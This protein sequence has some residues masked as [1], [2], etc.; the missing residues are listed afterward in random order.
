[1]SETDV[2]GSG[3]DCISYSVWSWSDGQNIVL[4]IGDCTLW[5]DGSI[6]ADM[7][8]IPSRT[9]FARQDNLICGG[10]DRYACNTYKWIALA[11]AAIVLSPRK[12]SWP[13]FC[14]CTG[15]TNNWW[16][17]LLYDD[18]TGCT[19]WRT[20]FPIQH[21]G[22]DHDYESTMTLWWSPEK[23]R[24]Q[25]RVQNQCLFFRPKSVKGNSS[26]SH[27]SASMFQ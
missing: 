6:M 23:A 24:P 2:N 13:L 12:S 27:F 16:I 26:P 7:N 19:A 1:M 8:I 17:M 3:R 10:M 20:R 22:V 25:N 18:K 9:A 5:T 15:R 21:H 14:Y 4:P 11:I